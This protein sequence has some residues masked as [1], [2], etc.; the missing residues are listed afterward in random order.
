MPNKSCIYGIIC[1]IFYCVK[2][3]RL[4]FYPTNDYNDYNDLDKVKREKKVNESE[5]K[6]ACV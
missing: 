4:I 1:R 3:V 6:D 5:I 2:K